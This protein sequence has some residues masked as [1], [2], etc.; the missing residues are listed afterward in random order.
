[1]M[2]FS[3]KTDYCT[4]LTGNQHI[5]S[6]KALLR[7]VAPND[8]LLFFIDT[9]V[10]FDKQ[11]LWVLLDYFSIDEITAARSYSAKNKSK[12]Q[13]AQI[14]GPAENTSPAE[15]KNSKKKMNTQIFNGI[16]SKMKQF[17][18]PPLSITTALTPSVNWRSWKQH[19]TV[20]LH[21]NS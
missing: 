16:I 7:S 4:R 19:L 9:S 14:P 1:M 6:D 17:K 21:P 3:E 5:D 13:P 8:S 2:T 10:E 15:K 20:I 12:K 18:K 11:L